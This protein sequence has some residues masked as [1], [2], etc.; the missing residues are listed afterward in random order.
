MGTNYITVRLNS[1]EDV[2]GGLGHLISKGALGVCD[3]TRGMNVA[4]TAAGKH[5][6]H[7]LLA[8]NMRTRKLTPKEIH[9]VL[10]KARKAGIKRNLDIEFEQTIFS[11]G[12]RAWLQALYGQVRYSLYLQK[13]MQIFTPMVAPELELCVR[14]GARFNVRKCIH[15]WFALALMCAGALDLCV[16]VQVP[17]VLH[18]DDDMVRFV[19]GCDTLEYF[20]KKQARFRETNKSLKFLLLHYVVCMRRM[21][22]PAEMQTMILRHLFSKLPFVN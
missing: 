10:Q 18:A 2:Y 22:I 13:R 21:H 8:M 7:C 16:R 9:K 11:I 17:K 20:Q 15:K 3:L 14:S 1:C 4:C 6:L 19:E 12:R 5:S